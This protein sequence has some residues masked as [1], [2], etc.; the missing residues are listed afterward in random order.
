MQLIYTAIFRI[1]STAPSSEFQDLVGFIC[2]SFF[3]V[4][5]SPA[6]SNKNLMRAKDRNAVIDVVLTTCPYTKQSRR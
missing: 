1:T 6:A 5:M 4:T 3:L 2:F